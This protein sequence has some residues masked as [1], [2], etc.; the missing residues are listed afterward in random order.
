M[1]YVLL[2]LASLL[3]QRCAQ[4]DGMFCKAASFNE[5]IRCSHQF[6]SLIF[7]HKFF[8]VWA[9][10][11]EKKLFIGPRHF[12]DWW[13]NLINSLLVCSWFFKLKF[14]T[15]SSKPRCSVHVLI[16]T[17]FPFK[18]VMSPSFHWACSLILLLLHCFS[19]KLL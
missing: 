13:N 19:Q 16:V 15:A 17:S 5:F 10:G 12:W 3:S 8:S 4:W 7:F 9:V 11:K 6:V 1:I 18:F 14:L 2:V